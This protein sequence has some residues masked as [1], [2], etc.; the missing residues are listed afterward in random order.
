[1]NQQATIND[2]LTREAVQI[3]PPAPI[4]LESLGGGKSSLHDRVSAMDKSAS[5]LKAPSALESKKIIL[6]SH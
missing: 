5:S 2:L 1:M 3:A 6:S 4:D